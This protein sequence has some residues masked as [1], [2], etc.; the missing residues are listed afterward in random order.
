MCNYEIHSID[1]TREEREYRLLVCSFQE[2]LNLEIWL[3]SKQ[4][5]KYMYVVETDEEI[6]EHDEIFESLGIKVVVEN[7]SLKYLSGTK[8][9]YTREGLNEGSKFD[10]PNVKDTCGCGESFNL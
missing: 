4:W 6:N 9:D 10:N 5:K 1:E 2:M 3:E 7:E 8:I